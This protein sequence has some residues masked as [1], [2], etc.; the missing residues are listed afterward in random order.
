MGASANVGVASVK[1]K[2]GVEG[3]LSAVSADH[4]RFGYPN[5]TTAEA[6]A[7]YVLIADGMVGSLSP[8]L[9]KLL[10]FLE[11]R[12]AGESALENSY[13]YGGAGAGPDGGDQRRGQRQRGEGPV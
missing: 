3:M 9:V 11:G 13:V 4:Y 7:Q 2:A 8:H 5:R 1:A 6:M 12:I 10:S